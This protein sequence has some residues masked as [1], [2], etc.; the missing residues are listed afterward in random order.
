MTIVPVSIMAISILCDVGHQNCVSISVEVG[1]NAV[2]NPKVPS[3]NIVV[4]SVFES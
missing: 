4:T 3:S 2:S 1:I